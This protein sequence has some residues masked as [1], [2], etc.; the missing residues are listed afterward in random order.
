MK[1]NLGRDRLIVRQGRFQTSRDELYRAIGV[2]STR[3]DE[4]ESFSDYM[5]ARKDRSYNDEAEVM[6]TLIA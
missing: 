5:N 1:R 3:A 4:E 6:S 2:A